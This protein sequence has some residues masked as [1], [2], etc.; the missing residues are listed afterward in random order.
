MRYISVLIA[1][2]L[3]CGSFVSTAQDDVVEVNLRILSGDGLD[4]L[5]EQIFEQVNA[6][7]D[8]HQIKARKVTSDH[9]IHIQIFESRAGILF[10]DV[11]PLIA[12]AAAISPLLDE[13]YPVISRVE[14]HPMDTDTASNLATGMILYTLGRCAEAHPYFEAVNLNLSDEPGYDLDTYRSIR[15]YQG[16]CAILKNDME[17]AIRYL[18]DGLYYEGGIILLGASTIHLA[19]AYLQVN[20]EQDALD[21]MDRLV[22]HAMPLTGGPN[23]YI[24]ALENRAQIY[25]LLGQYDSAIAD[26]DMLIEKR[27]KFNHYF[28]RGQMYRAIYEWDH[29]LADF[30]TAIERSPDYAEAYYQRGLLYYSILQTGIE[31]RPDALADFQRYLELAPDGTD[32]EAA[33]RYVENIQAELAA[34]TE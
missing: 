33:A 25:G 9:T 1:G 23:Y 31:T 14:I 17:Q 18:E 22:A 11:F 10:F 12:P 34:L 30:N 21:L 19:W 8:R 15:F 4:H 13:L 26:L 6:E 7:L 28:L 16:N 29:A 5:S 2:L 24:E 32:A 3:A 27:G 20:R